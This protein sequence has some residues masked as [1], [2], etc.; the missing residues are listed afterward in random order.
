[1]HHNAIQ[2][3]RGKG[4]GFTAFLL[5]AIPTGLHMLISAITFLIAPC[6]IPG[7]QVNPSSWTGCNN[8]LADG[9][10]FGLAILAVVVMVLIW[11]SALIVSIVAL[12][13]KSG[14]GWAISTLVLTVAG[15]GSMSWFP[16]MG[17]LWLMKEM[18]NFF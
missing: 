2:P 1:M 6:Y 13:K 17:F 9:N 18:S 15:F 14:S 4:L 10:A 11:S 5:W 16:L 8:T 3:A 7:G 12:A